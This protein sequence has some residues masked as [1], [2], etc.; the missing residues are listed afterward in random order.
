MITVKTFVFNSFQ[1]NTYILFD[2]TKS[3]IIVD[4]G[5]DSIAEQSILREY[6]DDY[7]LI[8]VAIVNTHCHVDHVLGC[9][10]IKRSFDIPFYIHP[11]EKPVLENVMSFGEFFGIQVE[12][13]PPPDKFL[14]HG[15][16]YT[17]G[18]SELA[19]MHIPGHSPGSITLY[20][21][22]DKFVITGDVLFKGSIGRTDLPGGD[23]QTLIDNIRKKLMVLPRDVT[24]FP[25]HGPNTTIG[26]E[27]DTN[28]FL[29]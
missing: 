12:A 2:E 20:N 21:V 10:Y 15:D 16:M 27:Y 8:P 5:M 3:C 9:N 28:P 23:Y 4:P 14:N 13:P 17:F 25:G 24:A 26:N 1:E 19:I 7:M 11:H 29:S 6:I 22:T 18:N